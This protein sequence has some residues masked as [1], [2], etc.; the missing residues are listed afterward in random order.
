MKFVKLYWE[1]ILLIS[2]IVC[3]AAIGEWFVIVGICL[4]YLIAYFLG[5]LGKK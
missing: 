2:I 1:H 5:I 4:G 3:M